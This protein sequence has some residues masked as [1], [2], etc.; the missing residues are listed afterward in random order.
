MKKAKDEIVTPA[1]VNN[2]TVGAQKERLARWFLEKKG[3]VILEMNYRCYLGE[4]DL[5]AKKE[6]YLVFVEVKYRKNE[7]KGYP[8]AAVNWQKQKK[9]SAVAKYYACGRG[10]SQEQAFRFDVVEILGNKI[11]VIENA[12]DYKGGNR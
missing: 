10:Y 9:I 11:R 2:R 8:G 7:S 3:Y 1:T 4:I 12:F 6:N 5:I